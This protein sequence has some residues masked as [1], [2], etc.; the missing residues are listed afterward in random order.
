MN[1]EL[2]TKTATTES[3]KI[4]FC[5]QIFPMNV[6]VSAGT[7]V[8]VTNWLFGWIITYTF[9]FML[10]WNASGKYLEYKHV[11]IILI[12]TIMILLLDN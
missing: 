8:T 4:L 2:Y 10:E 3:N 1:L 6:K 5:L 9:N 12:I 11:I 7:L